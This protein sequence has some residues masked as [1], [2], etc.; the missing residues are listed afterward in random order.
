MLRTVLV[1]DERPALKALEH[2]LNHY[3]DI[4]IVG[5]FTD[6]DQA[7][8]LV[9]SDTIHLLFLD[10]DMPKLNGIAAAK[11]ILANNTNINI[12]FVT[13]YS[14]FAVEAF[15]VKA[16]D[17]IMKP[18]SPKRLN[19][20]M[21]RIIQNHPKSNS[22]AMQQKK[23]VFLNK[24]IAKKITDPDDIPQQAQVLG[25]DFTQSFSLFFL[26]LS[27][28]NNQLMCEKP[29]G[30]HT[31]INA[32]IE[33]LSERA[34]LV[35]WQTH[36]G[37]GILDYTVSASDDCKTEEL[38]M[39]GHLKAIA[40]RHFPNITVALGIAERCTKIESFTN[41]YVQARN[42]AVIGIHVSPSLGVYHFMDSGFLPVLNQYVNKQSSDIL[43]DSTIGKLLEHDRITGTE[44]FRTMEKIILSNS[45]Q[46]VA[47][48]LFIHYKTVLF[49]KQAIE[50]ILG[51]SMNS[52]AGRTMLGVALTLFYLR[53]IPLINNR[54]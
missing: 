9:K 11:K 52:F 21:E 24:L 23:N 47:N 37:I 50:K 2:L 1:D 31:A 4:E 51:M 44:L 25:I 40:A 13:A 54:S 49:R 53:N 36:Q 16:F 42:A 39:A 19:K 32:L 45:L 22:F 5:A 28:T 6:I 18:V 17:Y 30:K 12:I 33:E 43:I 35:V 7:L 10:I 46:D 26:L 34:G 14:H 15:E 48:T 29:D 20:T 27:D 41:R 8:E 3:R 38:A